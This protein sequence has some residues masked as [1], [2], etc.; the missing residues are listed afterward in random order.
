MNTPLSI[1]DEYRDYIFGRNKIEGEYF[2]NKISEDDR[3]VI[4]KEYMNRNAKG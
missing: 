4:H 3:T 2:A 1:Q